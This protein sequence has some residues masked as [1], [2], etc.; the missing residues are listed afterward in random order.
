[1]KEG[2]LLGHIV[3]SQGICIDLERVES[4]HKVILPRNIKEIQSFL[5]KVN[6][7]QRFI[8]TFVEI[9][10]H[11]TCMVRKD[12]EIKWDVDVRDSFAAI[13]LSLTKA[14]TLASPYFS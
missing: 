11:I 4:I 9:I 14:P 8:P 13:K 2:R 3:T 1:M 6:F 12:Q 5:G 7:L 10:K